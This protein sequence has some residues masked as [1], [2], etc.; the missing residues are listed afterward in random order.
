MR[1]ILIFLTAASLGACVSESAVDPLTELNKINMEEQV[2]D[3]ELTLSE[4]E[5]YAMVQSIPSPIQSTALMQAVGAEY[6]E[7]VLQVTDKSSNYVSWFAQSTNLGIYLADMG[8]ANLYGETKKSM[9]YMISIR[10]LA[11]K[12]KIGQFFDLETIKKLSDKKDDIDGLINESQ[13][14]FQKMNDY[15]QKQN[16]GK[17]SVAMIMGGWIEGLYLSAKIAQLNPTSQELLDNVAQQKLSLSTIELFL[18]LYSSDKYFADFKNDF[19]EL[20]KAYD[21]VDIVYYDGEVTYTEDAD[22]NLI[23][24]DTSTSE[25]VISQSDLN[26]IEKRIQTIRK[27]LVN[28]K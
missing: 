24:E 1:K 2:Q 13:M 22:G 9:D 12:L 8:Y 26:A 16:R 23:V 27:K 28:L 5:F 19:N 4:E 6:K 10:D 18:E 21:K 20:V 15:L 25:M 14:N 7:N 3:S 17:V 11:D